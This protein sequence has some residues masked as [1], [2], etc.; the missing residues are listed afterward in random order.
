MM[1]I[2]IKTLGLDGAKFFPIKQDFPARIRSFG[3]Q[4]LSL[5]HHLVLWGPRPAFEHP[6]TAFCAKHGLDH[7]RSTTFPWETEGTSEGPAKPLSSW[8]ASTR[9]GWRRVFHLVFPMALAVVAPLPLLRA[10]LQQHSPFQPL[11]G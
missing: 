11:G 6:R 9:E 1:D 7:S 8:A 5:I 2:W 4:H 3:N 10:G